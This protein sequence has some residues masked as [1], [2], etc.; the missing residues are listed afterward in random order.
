[1]TAWRPIDECARSAI[2]SDNS[3]TGSSL[4]SPR[5]GSWIPTMARKKNATPTPPADLDLR[6]KARTEP[7]DPDAKRFDF[8]LIDTGWN[9]AVGKVVRSHLALIFSFAKQDGFYLLSPEQSV[10]IIRRAPNL[11]GHDPILLVYD[12]YAPPTRTSRGYRGFRLNLGLIKHP[13]QALARLQ[14]FLRFVAIN[15]TAVPLDRKIRAELYREGLDG[16]VKILR[17]ASTELI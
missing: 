14:E 11:M 8:F 7:L 2:N 16:M 5:F 1:M 15:R 3:L 17:E 9:I 12:L 13:E 10:E 4:L 6:F